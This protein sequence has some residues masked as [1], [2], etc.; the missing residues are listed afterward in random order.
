[1]KISSRVDYALS[2]VLRVADKYGSRVPVTIT[3]I[4][5]KEKIKTDYVGQIL[6]LLKKSGVLKSIRGRR[7]G[8]LLKTRPEN[9]SVLTIIKAIEQEV[10]KP[11]CFREKGRRKR[12]IH[13]SDCRILSLWNGLKSNMEKYLDNKNLKELLVLRKKEKSW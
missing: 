13:F 2:C 1:M 7:G 3:E 12:C 9:I 6:I 10:L 4:S 8:Y 5:R 11:V